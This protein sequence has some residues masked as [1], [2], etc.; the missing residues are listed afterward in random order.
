MTMMMTTLNRSSTESLV[1]MT[2]RILEKL[3][4][5]ILQASILQTTTTMK[6]KT[7]RFHKLFNNQLSKLFNKSLRHQP[8]ILQS[9]MKLLQTTLTP[10]RLRAM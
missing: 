7:I 3:K 9:L 6:M 4:M 10:L 2:V 5:K 1:M 8:L